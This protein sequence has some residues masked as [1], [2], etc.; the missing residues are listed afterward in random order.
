MES[1]Y[2]AFS[3]TGDYARRDVLGYLGDISYLLDSGVKVAL[4]YGDRDYACNWIGG[5]DVSLAINYT[6][7]KQFRSAGYTPIQT[8]SSYVGGQVRQHGNFSFSRVFGKVDH[9]DHNP[10]QGLTLTTEAGHLVPAYQPET[11]YE[12]FMRAMTNR[13]IATGEQ[14]TAENDSYSTTGTAT[15]FQ[16]KNEVPVPPAPT[17]YVRA[18]L[19]TCPDEQKLAVISGTAVVRAGIV[20]DNNTE[21]L[22]NGS[23]SNSTGGRST[24]SSSMGSDG[25]GSMSD[26]NETS[27]GGASPSAPS[28]AT[29]SSL[30]VE[31]SSFVLILAAGVLMV[32]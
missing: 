20:V 8:N 32:L 4:V 1:V 18:F 16:I 17:C 3:S 25:A 14:S 6:D 10:R 29:R 22:F 30:H 5:E 28:T 13:D 12:I 24:G 15:I 2:N 9:Q 23:G 7:S 26:G 27:T 21:S 19:S 31:L 11:A